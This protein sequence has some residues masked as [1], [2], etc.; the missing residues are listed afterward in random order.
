MLKLYDIMR[1]KISGVDI[2]SPIQSNFRHVL[3]LAIS[4]KR[5]KALLWKKIWYL[6]FWKTDRVVMSNTSKWKSTRRVFCKKGVLRNF[7]KFTGRHLCQSLLIKKETLAQMF[8]YEFY[9]ISKNTFSYRTP[10]VTASPR[11][12]SVMQTT[13]TLKLLKTAQ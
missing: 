5:P 4:N 11:S 13:K 10:P 2:C 7:A 9:E 6:C 8:S 12:K 1:S 3:A